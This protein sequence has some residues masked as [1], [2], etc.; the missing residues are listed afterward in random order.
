M[1]E[2]SRVVP[3]SAYLDSRGD[4]L[5]CVYNGGPHDFYGVWVVSLST[6]QSVQVQLFARVGEKA[7]VKGSLGDSFTPG[8]SPVLAV[9]TGGGNTYHIV[10]IVVPDISSVNC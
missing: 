10:P 9:T 6:G 8:T 7:A 4:F 5:I 1:R 3:I 2:F